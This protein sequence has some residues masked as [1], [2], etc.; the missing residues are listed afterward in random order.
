M[1]YNLL[2]ALWCLIGFVS[3]FFVKF[4]LGDLTER[5]FNN[6]FAVFI[7][8]GW[9]ASLAADMMLTAYNTAWQVHMIMATVAGAKFGGEALFGIEAIQI[10]R[11]DD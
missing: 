10:D 11:G 9:L 1:S 6:L 3:G 7:L 5:E 8:L 4:A 2:D